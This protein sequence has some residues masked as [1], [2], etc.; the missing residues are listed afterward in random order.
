[1]SLKYIINSAMKE[2]CLDL[3][4]HYRKTSG[5]QPKVFLQN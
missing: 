3:L 1:M 5:V 2:Y 4:K